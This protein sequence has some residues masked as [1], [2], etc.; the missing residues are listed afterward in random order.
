MLGN[1]LI[2]MSRHLGKWARRT[3][4]TCYR[5]YDRDVPDHPLILDWYDGD[6]VVYVHTRKKDATPEAR[7]GWMEGALAE[8]AEA[9][10]ISRDRMH[11]KERGRRTEGEQY[12][13]LGSSRCEREVQEFGLKFLV[14]LDDYLDTG[15]FLDHRETRRIIRE[16]SAG[17]RFLNLFAYTGSFTVYAAAGGAVATHTVDISKTYL[18]WAQR[19][20]DLNVLVGLQ[21]TLERA[22]VLRWLP[23][24]ARSGQRFDLILCDPPTFSNSARMTGFLDVDEQHPQLINQ[25]LDLLTPEGVLYF[26]TN[27]RSFRLR[28]DEIRTDRAFE[29][30]KRT[31]PLD[32][33]N[34]QIH[35]CWE[36]RLP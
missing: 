7:A 18:D 22:D 19:N 4:V 8:I 21:H 6:L 11:V 17:K 34:K 31:V 1:R 10:Q 25:C 16:Q 26:S 13:R 28:P 2:R 23:D 33:R 29:I 5:L 9:L 20:L 12:R 35:R 3:G 24:A 27:Q 36:F 15:L 30:S 32:F 14:N